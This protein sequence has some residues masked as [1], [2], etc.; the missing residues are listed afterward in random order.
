[1]YKLVANGYVVRLEDN[2]Y[3]PPSMDNADYLD[4]LAWKGDQVLV[5]EE[6]M[7]QDEIAAIERER[8]AALTGG[9]MYKGRLFHTDNEFRI[10]L[11]D[12]LMG[13]EKGLLSGNQAIRTLSNEIVMLSYP[14]LLELKL[15]VG[16]MRQTVYAQSWR[17]K[18]QV[19]NS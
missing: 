1:M 3:I 6:P 7:A 18:D 17:K 4:F 16:L 11:S 15:A 10:D 14:E 5:P 19:R 2:A 9:V 8:D 12:M 13:Y